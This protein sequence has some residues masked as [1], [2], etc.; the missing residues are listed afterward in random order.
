MLLHF[1]VPSTCSRYIIIQTCNANLASARV[2]FSHVSALFRFNRFMCKQCTPRNAKQTIL[3]L[4]WSKHA[5]RNQLLTSSPAYNDLSATV[6]II[7]HI[8]IRPS[9]IR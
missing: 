3:H 2:C 1:K 8:V 4:L 6:V 7:I 9:S 5:V